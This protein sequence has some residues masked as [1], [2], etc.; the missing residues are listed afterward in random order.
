M[1][2]LMASLTTVRWRVV[3]S[4]LLLAAFLVSS[5][6][7]SAQIASLA[8]FAGTGFALCL[9]AT[10][11][12]RAGAAVCGLVDDPDG[13]RKLHAIS[14]PLSGG[15]AVFVSGTIATVAGFT[16]PCNCC[17]LWDKGASTQL[18]A[19][20]LA[21]GGICLLGVADDFRLLRGWHKLLGQVIIVSILITTPGFAVRMVSFN[22]C[23]LD[24]G[25]LS[26][27][28]T[29]LWLLGCINS[30]NLLDGMDGLL[31]SVGI[32]IFVAIGLLALGNQQWLA[33]AL[34]FTMVGVLLA[35]LIYN[36]P[37][38]NV[39]LGDA[40]SML[41]GL[42]VGVLATK[43]TARAGNAIPLVIP[44]A[45]LAIP[46][47]D[48]IAAIVR[49]KLT[50]RSI[51]TTDRGHL[52]H[53]LLRRGWSPRKVLV[54][55]N[56]FCLVPILGSLA[57]SLRQYDLP[58]L[59]ATS[60]II[61][62]LVASRIFGYSEFQLIFNK[63]KR[64][65]FMMRSTAGRSGIH[66]S[67]VRLQG[68]ADWQDLLESVAAKAIDLKLQ[69]I[70]LNIDVAAIHEV[71]HATWSRSVSKRDGTTEWRVEVPVVLHGQNIGSLAV[72][73]LQDSE[74]TGQTV[75]RLIQ[76][77]QEFDTTRVVHRHRHYFLNLPHQDAGGA[78]RLR[79]R[80]RWPARKH[81]EEIVYTNDDV[82]P[83]ASI[84]DHGVLR[85]LGY[86]ETACGQ[87]SP[88]T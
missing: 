63:I 62:F 51:Y 7:G 48:T 77:M 1:D 81:H 54:W 55:M 69:S 40:G 71:Y 29:L 43:A 73:G 4:W 41:I 23:I 61:V 21:G 46:I 13:R 50:G 82:G 49:R 33:A 35:F 25:V 38:A 88:P 10:P 32:L 75:F 9:I 34:A 20:F 39:F 70:R 56:L 14:I 16:L 86:V 83:I 26:V 59:I 2:M 47:L 5:Y 66:R 3:N 76:L 30:I 28:L 72:A 44:F 11:L 79:V 8:L 36:F 60:G 78:H 67:E 6:F 15:I 80:Q 37:P 52:H 22:G 53:C 84:L 12:A 18:V 45:L 85:E 68:E 57:T 19:I 27:P 24:L 42:L 65:V 87:K 17:S 64:L 31:T 74:P 58:A